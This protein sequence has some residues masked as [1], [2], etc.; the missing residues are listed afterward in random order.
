MHF[1]KQF[2][3]F[4][5]VPCKYACISIPNESFFLFVCCIALVTP[6]LYS[7]CVMCVCVS[8]FRYTQKKQQTSHARKFK[9]DFYPR[10][11]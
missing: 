10:L 7:T 5:Y 3:F 4:Y 9:F 8:V 6:L 11:M 1:D 2:H